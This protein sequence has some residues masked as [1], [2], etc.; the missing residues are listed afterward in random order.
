MND[1]TG[2]EEVCELPAGV[3][4]AVVAVSP[5]QEAGQRAQ[6]VEHH[7]GEGVPVAETETRV[8]E[9]WWGISSIMK[10]QY[11]SSQ[12]AFSDSVMVTV[13]QQRH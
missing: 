1:V 5:G 12:P 8:G 2:G 9:Y 4:G 11:S 3:A 13:G 6:E 7:H 10:I